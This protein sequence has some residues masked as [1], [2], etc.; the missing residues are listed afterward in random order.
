MQ[1]MPSIRAAYYVSSSLKYIQGVLS[2]K[3]NAGSAT[4]VV[5][6]IEKKL[7]RAPSCTAVDGK[8]ISHANWSITYIRDT[9]LSL[10]NDTVCKNLFLSYERQPQF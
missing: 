9:S 8:D 6:P 5:P 10:S 3:L 4:K 7:I 1:I 2:L